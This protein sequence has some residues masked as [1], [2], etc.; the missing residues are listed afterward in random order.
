MFSGI[1]VCWKMTRSWFENRTLPC[2][3]KELFCGVSWKQNDFHDRASERDPGI[4]DWLLGSLFSY[5]IFILTRIMSKYISKYHIILYLYILLIKWQIRGRVSHFSCNSR[6]GPYGLLV[7]GEG[8][9]RRIRIFWF[10]GWENWVGGSDFSE[11]Y[12]HF[13]SIRNDPATSRHLTIL[14]SFLYSI[15]P[16]WATIK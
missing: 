7:S 10:D 2:L 9:N 12:F 11:M 8:V 16:P 6:P 15:P 1:S 5:T 3:S 4:L 14:Q 13:F